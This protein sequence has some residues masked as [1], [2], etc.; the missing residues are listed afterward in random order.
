MVIFSIESNFTVIWLNFNTLL[1]RTYF[2]VLVL[3]RRLAFF[4]AVN[5]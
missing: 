2:V 5:I 4:E 1:L 3:H